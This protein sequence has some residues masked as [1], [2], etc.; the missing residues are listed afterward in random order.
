MGARAAPTRPTS[1]RR[2]GRAAGRPPVASR[3]PRAPGGARVADVAAQ[4]QVALRHRGHHRAARRT[5][6]ATTAAASSGVAGAG[7][8]SARSVPTRRA[9]W[10]SCERVPGRAQRD[11]E[12]RGRDRGREQHHRR[13]GVRPARG[14]VG[15][16]REHQ[17]GEREPTPARTASRS[18]T[19]RTA[20]TVTATRHTT[21]AT[22]RTTSPLVSAVAGCECSC[23]Q[24]ATATT[25]SSTSTPERRRHPTAARGPRR[26]G[27]ESGSD[28][29]QGQQHGAGDHGQ[30]Q[31][32]GDGRVL[33]QPGCAH[34]RQPGQ[35]R[36]GE[37]GGRQRQ[38]DGYGR[39]QGRL[40]QGGSELLAAAEPERRRAGP[41]RR[42]GR[43][44]PGGRPAAGRRARGS[45]PAA[46]R[47]GRWTGSWP[48]G[49]A[50]GRSSRAGRRRPG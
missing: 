8:T 16:E 48:A 46:A 44:R 1:S 32:P 42:R 37:R 45:S 4:R 10:S 26:A 28:E 22:V 41:A 18:G 34:R 13:G 11:P 3:G 6:A 23:H 5:V 49:R 9:A 27:V 12:G 40:D 15:G 35:E 17:A 24:A 14:L 30:H 19:A 43:P 36:V 39:E 21:G 29:G 2:A 20:T 33:G 47:P 31:V 7:S 38:H 25:T 50:A